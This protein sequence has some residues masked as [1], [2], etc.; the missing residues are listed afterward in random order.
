MLRYELAL[1]A[2]RL[3]LLSVGGN[4]DSASSPAGSLDRQVPSVILNGVKD[5]GAAS[6]DDRETRCFVPQHDTIGLTRYSE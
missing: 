4:R 5:L 3:N 1:A 2:S 6:T